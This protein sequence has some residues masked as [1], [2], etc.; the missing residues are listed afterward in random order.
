[1]NEYTS[2]FEFPKN[3]DRY[4][5]TLSKIYD[6]DGKRQLHEIIVN[7]Q[8]RIHEEWSYDNWNGGMYGHA[9]FL[10]LPDALFL[11]M[12]KNKDD[13]QN[14]IKDDLN[15][16]KHIQDE[17]IDQVFVELEDT[18]DGEWRKESGLLLPEKRVV[19]TH[20]LER[21]W[22]TDGFR[23]FLSHRSNVKTET[24]NL[25]IQLQLFGMSCF[26]AH[27]DIRP[28]KA[29]Q[30]EIENALASMD[31]LVALMTPDFHESEWTDQ[32]VGFAFGRGVPII[33]V[34]LGKNPYG[35]VGKFQA[36]PGKWETAAEKIAK[37]LINNDRMFSAYVQAL[38]KCPD[39]DSGNILAKVLPNIERLNEAQI[40]QLV[41]AYNQHNELWDSFGFSGS[42]P[43]LYG[44][45]LTFH[46]NRLSIRQFRRV[47][48]GS[49]REIVT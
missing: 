20:I 45:G 2:K 11:A 36:L 47:K 15:E 30:D 42:K 41:T 26:V 44:Q 43:T 17:Y 49:I 23:V 29:W 16:I 9:V 27:E 7:A 25:K 31:C 14:Q 5:A 33:P 40:D 21:I 35:F 22:G 34:Q 13:I 48:S 8:I 32:E 4:L 24:A 28:T 46:L 3:I 19:P 1:M 37:T 10:S 18:K 6:Q 39:W 38:L 12:V